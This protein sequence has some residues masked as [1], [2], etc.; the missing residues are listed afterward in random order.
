MFLLSLSINEFMALSARDHQVVIRLF[1]AEIDRLTP[2]V[3]SGMPGHPG[4]Q[5]HVD[6]LCSLR[7]VRKVHQGRLE[8]LQPEAVTPVE[9]SHALAA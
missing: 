4:Y 7:S 3:Q 2:L 6:D 9:V 8:E 1:D 5:E